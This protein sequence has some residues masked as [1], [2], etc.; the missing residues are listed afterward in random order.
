MI[1]LVV[2]GEATQ[3]RGAPEVE[4]LLETLNMPADR[5]AIMVNDEVVTRQRRATTALKEND[6]I[7]ILT[8]AGGG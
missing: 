3:Y 8:F 1:T 2:N 6:R 7:E 5:V 4:S